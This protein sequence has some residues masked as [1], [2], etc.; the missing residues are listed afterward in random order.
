MK[1]HHGHAIVAL[2]RLEVLPRL[3]SGVRGVPLGSDALRWHHQTASEVWGGSRRRSQVA[4]ERAV[5]G[6]NAGFADR[7]FREIAREGRSRPG[8]QSGRP[9]QASSSAFC[10]GCLSNLPPSRGTL[11]RLLTRASW[12]LFLDFP[13]KFP[14]WLL[15]KSFFLLFFAW[16]EPILDQP[17]PPEAHRSQQKTKTQHRFN[18]HQEGGASSKSGSRER[19]RERERTSF[20]PRRDPRSSRWQASSPAAPGP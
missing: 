12:A 3:V 8:F 4:S 19:E 11:E 7:T 6:P 1:P 5:E 16:G 9:W 13:G 14:I 10:S 15:H 2:L 17:S 18:R 20:C